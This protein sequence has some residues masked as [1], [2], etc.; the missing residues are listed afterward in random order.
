MDSYK[1]VKGDNSLL[2]KDLE[3]YFEGIS[4][5]RFGFEALTSQV[6]KVREIVGDKVIFDKATLEDIMILKNKER[7]I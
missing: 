2:T 1:I 7:Y 3:K 4:K 6:S 5:N